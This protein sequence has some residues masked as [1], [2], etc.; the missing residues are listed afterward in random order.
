MAI[1]H[2]IQGT[3]ADLIKMAMIK[4]SERIKKEFAPGEVRMLLQIHD[5]LVFEVREEL[6]PRAEKI[7]KQ[8]MEAVYKMKAPIR[9]EVTAGNS[10]GECK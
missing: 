7:I 3:A 10:W 6:I 5:E 4:L 9:V 2:P 1:N 8:E